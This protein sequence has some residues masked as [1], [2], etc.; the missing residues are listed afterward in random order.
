MKVLPYGT[1]EIPSVTAQCG[2]NADT[3]ITLPTELPGTAQIKVFDKSDNRLQTVYRVFLRAAS[4]IEIETS[5]AQEGNPGENCLDDDL[6]TRWAVEG[7]SWGI[8]RFAQPQ[9]IS[10]VWLATWKA[11][12]RKLKF[13]IEVSEDGENFKQV[14]SGKTAAT[15]DELE[16]I[17]IPAGT[18]KAVKLV[19]HGTTTG[20]WNSVLE[21]NF[22]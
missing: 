16:E 19:M 11:A 20:T 10:S 8:F 1:T 9:K 2:E 4:N 6:L 12:E 18:Y 7:E 13:S 21:V 14:F 5:G 17:K 3:Q 22:K 15:K